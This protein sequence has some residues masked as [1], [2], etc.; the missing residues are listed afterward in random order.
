[1]KWAWRGED[2]SDRGEVVLAVSIKFDSRVVNVYS[3]G[4]ECVEVRTN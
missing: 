4:D 2:E 3:E 1:M